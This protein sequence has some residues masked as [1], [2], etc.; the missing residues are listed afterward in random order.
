M[1]STSLSL[2]VAH[3]LWVRWNGQ[4][5]VL[6]SARSI[7][8]GV[9]WKSLLLIGRRAFISLGQDDCLTL[10]SE[11][12]LF[13]Q[14]KSTSNGLMIPLLMQRKE[15]LRARKVSLPTRYTPL[16]LRLPPTL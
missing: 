2:R 15:H 6:C 10:T 14:Q 1:R 7:L 16:V 4:T 13:L 11:R 3:I 8:E 5:G 9:L 12:L